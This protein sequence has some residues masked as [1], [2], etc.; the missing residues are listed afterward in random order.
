MN[1]A[2]NS[3]PEEFRQQNDRERLDDSFRRLLKQITQPNVQLPVA[4]TNCMVD[5]HERIELHVHR[6]AVAA[7]PQGF[8][9]LLKNPLRLLQWSF[10]FFEES[11]LTH[12]S[13]ISFVRTA[14]SPLLSK[15]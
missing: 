6:L 2:W 14:P 5:S 9:R 13:L 15:A 1:D 10:N 11:Q 8:N 7:E 4:K 12:C 3:A